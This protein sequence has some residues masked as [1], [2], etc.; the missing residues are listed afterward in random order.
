MVAACQEVRARPGWERILE[1][2]A[3]RHGASSANLTCVVDL[4]D[5]ISG[6]YGPVQDYLDGVL[7]G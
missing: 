7:G 4:R 2:F 3:I 6:L 5:A 1:H